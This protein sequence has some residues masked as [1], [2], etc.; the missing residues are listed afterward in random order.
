M[1]HAMTFWLITNH[2]HDG[3][4]IGYNGADKFIL[5][6]KHLAK[7]EIIEKQ[8]AEERDL[9][10]SLKSLSTYNDNILPI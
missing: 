8:M 6:S 2:I 7:E 5:S 10:I 4:V 9:L 3:A 1:C